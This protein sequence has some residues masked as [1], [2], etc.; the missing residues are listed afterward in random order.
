MNWTDKRL[1]FTENKTTY[2][3]IPLGDDIVN[4]LWIPDLYFIEE[5]NSLLH[6]LLT[7]NQLAFI[8][9]NGDVFYSGR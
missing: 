5:R 3:I 9:K 1:D 8:H 4:S 2:D 7:S 6:G